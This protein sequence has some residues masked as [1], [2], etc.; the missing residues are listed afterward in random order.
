MCVAMGEKKSFQT[1]IE[2]KDGMLHI[3]RMACAVCL[4][5]AEWR[6]LLL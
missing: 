2:S 4:T 1:L 6:V 3:Y 5:I